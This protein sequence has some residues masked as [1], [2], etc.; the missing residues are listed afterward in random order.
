MKFE[1]IFTPEREKYILAEMKEKQNNESGYGSDFMRFDEFEVFLPQ[2]RKTLLNNLAAGRYSP[3]PVLLFERLKS[4]GKLRVLAK[5]TNID[6]F[7]LKNIADALYDFVSPQFSEACHAY[8]RDHGTL[9]AIDRIRYFAEQG[10]EF[11]VECDV[12]NYFDSINHGILI[13]QLN[14]L[15]PDRRIVNIIKKYLVAPREYDDRIEKLNKGIVQ[16]SPL[17]PLLSNIYLSGLDNFCTEKSWQYVRYADNMYFVTNNRA[18]AEVILRTV[19]DRLRTEYKL[20]LNYQKSGIYDI[21]KRKMLGYCLKRLPNGQ[22]DCIRQQRQVAKAYPSWQHHAIGK[23]DDLYYLLEDGILTKRDYTLFFENDTF[24]SPIPLHTVE[25]LNVFANITFNSRFFENILK[26]NIPLHFHNKFGDCLGHLVPTQHVA[27]SETMLRQT[28]I[29]EN[30]PERRR[31]ALAIEK[32]SLH[33]MTSVLLYYLYRK[34]D[35]RLDTAVTRM[36]A[37][38]K[39]LNAC[40][41]PADMLLIEARA[42]KLY[43]NTLNFVIGQPGFCFI[44]RSRRPPEDPIN[45]LISFGNTVLYNRCSDLIHKTSLDCRIAFVHASNHRDESLNLD[46]ADIFKP[47]IVDRVILSLI[48]RQQINANDHFEEMPEGGIYLSKEGK[49]IFIQEFQYKLNSLISYKGNRISY[50]YLITL[51][52]RSLLRSIIGKKFSYKPYKGR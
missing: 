10:C 52:I 32:A 8:R 51:E 50:E 16:G 12:R 7:I 24:V 46:I 27:R 29:Y 34:H 23:K 26:C 3:H 1:D 39:R 19:R 43:Y 4:T 35:I 20:Q 40:K 38:T 18:D 47:I 15:I 14:A 31:Y 33:N 17:S 44:Q 30:L 9:T 6:I 48:N 11:L 37:Y 28:S 36:R 41:T 5:Y 13:K 49:K 22:V 2:N 21:T 45:A 42:R 25:S